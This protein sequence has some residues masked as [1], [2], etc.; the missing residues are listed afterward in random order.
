MQA[1][2]KRLAVEDDG[3]KQKS[4]NAVWRP[5]STSASSCKGLSPG[6]ETI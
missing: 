4:L 5:V 1:R 6:S 3:K 2:K